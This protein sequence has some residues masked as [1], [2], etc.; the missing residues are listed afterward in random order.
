MQRAVRK[1]IRAV[2]GQRL[3]LVA[4]AD[5][6]QLGDGRHFSREQRGEARRRIQPGADGGAALCQWIKLL[7]R[8][9]VADD[10]ALDL[11]SVTGKFLPE[12]EWRRV[13]GMGAADL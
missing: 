1:G 10:A 8:D 2:R 4:G 5:K 12:R 13:L 9:P 6:R 7:E 3:E 11:R